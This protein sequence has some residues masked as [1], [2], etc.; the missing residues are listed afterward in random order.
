MTSLII[1]PRARSDISGIIDGLAHDASPSVALRYSSEFDNAFVRLVSFPRLGAPRPRFGAAVRIW[2]IEPYVVY[3]R[4]TEAI[5]IVRILRILHGRR[6]FTR[7]LL[8]G[9]G[10]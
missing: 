8:S 3:Y 10:P 5:D 2:T 4:Y 1:A 6:K 9:S 7:K